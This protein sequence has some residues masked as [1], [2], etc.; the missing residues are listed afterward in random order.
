MR[1]RTRSAL[2]WPGR[3]TAC[4]GTWPMWPSA[5]RTALAAGACRAGRAR[6]AADPGLR[7]QPR[8]PGSPV[9]EQPPGAVRARRRRRHQGRSGGLA[10]GR[11]DRCWPMAATRTS[12]RGP[13]SSSS[14][15][16]PLRSAPPRSETLADIAGQCDG[17]RCDM[18]MLVTNQV[19]ARTW[20][21]RA[22]PAPT[23]EFWP[24]VLAQ[25][26]VAS[27]ATMAGIRLPTGGPNHLT[28]L[29]SLRGKLTYAVSSHL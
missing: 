11:R 27:V 20:W 8:G 5:A 12:R 19:F 15:R 23:A 16:S 6:G 29:K 17:I 25:P 4:A 10:G 3:R 22:G 1:F 14:T 13:M 24:E 26:L 2:T 21:N 28:T 7:A 9:G 18:A